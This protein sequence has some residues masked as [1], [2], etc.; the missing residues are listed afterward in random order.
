MSRSGRSRVVT[1]VD[2]ETE[3]ALVGGVRAGDEAAFDA[4]FAAF[5]PRLFGFLA[6]LTGRREVA[7]DLLE[8]TWLRFV[9]HADRLD[10]DTQLG[11]WLFA[12]ARN[13]HVSH[14]R[15]RSVEAAVAGG[16]SLW[17]ARA[18]ETP[19][20]ATARNE[21]EQRIERGLAALSAPLR[22][23]LLLVAIEGMSASEA[24]L[25]CGTTAVAI[26][27]RVR[28]ARGLLAGQLGDVDQRRWRTGA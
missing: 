11:A 24:A 26:R 18:V 13:L 2:R 14:C 7:E 27:Q 6:R 17:P 4:I 28:R 19:F 16:L 9:R 22:E 12:V 23:A 8:E 15:T 20:D 1:G 5:N 25:V 21:F 3:L 10:A